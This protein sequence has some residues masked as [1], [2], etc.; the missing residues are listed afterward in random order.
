MPVLIKVWQ[1]GT[2]ENICVTMSNLKKLQ[3]SQVSQWDKGYTPAFK[4]SLVKNNTV[5]YFNILYKSL[6]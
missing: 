2:K 4:L 1:I 6:K 3:L 5:N